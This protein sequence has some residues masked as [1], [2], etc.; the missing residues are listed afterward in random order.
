MS[1]SWLIAIF[2]AIVILIGVVY[3]VAVVDTRP[4]PQVVPTLDV[5]RPTQP[6]REL[7][8]TPTSTP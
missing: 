5:L 1:K 4:L 8:P 7:A 3:K 2:V 6:I